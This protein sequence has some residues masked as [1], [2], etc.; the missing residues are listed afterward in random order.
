MHMALKHSH[1][2]LVALSVLLFFIRFFSMQLGANFI[3]AKIFKIAP[4]IID[5]LLLASGIALI[6][7]VG[8]SLW[9]INW[10]TV[11]L[12]LVVAYIVLG[13]IAMKTNKKGLSWTAALFALLCVAAIGH[14]AMTKAF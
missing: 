11:K 3:R 6:V 2:L 7:T 14:L 12:I 9:P 5:T 13:I 4:H 10:L 8:Y 1:M